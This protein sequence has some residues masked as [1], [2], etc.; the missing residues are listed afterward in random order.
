MYG[1]V[2]NFTSTFC[3]C[4]YPPGHGDV[5]P[6]L[7]NSGK[8]EALISQVCVGC[9]KLWCLYRYVIGLFVPFSFPCSTLLS[10]CFQGKEYVF[11]ANSDNLGAIVDLSILLYHLVTFCCR[12]L[13]MLYASL[14]PC[15]FVITVPCTRIF[16]PV[17]LYWKYRNLKPFGQQQ[18]W[19]LHGGRVYKQYCLVVLLT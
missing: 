13:P 6:S 11:V 15:P 14:C 2:L 12:N 16:S 9:F 5:F 3:T 10:I 4:R 17:I 8:L 7:M 1:Y 18:E 19:V